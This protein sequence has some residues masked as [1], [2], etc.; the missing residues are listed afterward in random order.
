[1]PLLPLFT[2]LAGYKTY[3]MIAITALDAI[4]TQLGWWEE[5]SI[6]QI[7]ELALT[8]AALRQGVKSK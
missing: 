7:S 4:G 8:A 2:R 3:I 1:M 5:G 6:R